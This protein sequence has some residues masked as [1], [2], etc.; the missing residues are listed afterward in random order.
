MASLKSSLEIGVRFQFNLKIDI[1]DR[2]F[3]RK[4]VAIGL[5]ISALSLWRDCVK[6]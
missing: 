6:R 3:G 1:T 4:E 2:D 5:Q